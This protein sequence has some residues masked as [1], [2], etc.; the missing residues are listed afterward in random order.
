MAA[1]WRQD[2]CQ[3]AVRVKCKCSY[4]CPHTAHQEI[5]L[6][7]ALQP[8]PQIV[9]VPNK[10]SPAASTWWY[11]GGQG[12]SYPLCLL[13]AWS[14]DREGPAYRASQGPHDKIDPKHTLAF[15]L[16]IS[17]LAELNGHHLLT[18][19]PFPS[20]LPSIHPFPKLCVLVLLKAGPVALERC[21]R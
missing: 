8:S 16:P 17:N 12:S 21:T 14:S 13:R 3:G 9:Q 19:N 18:R 4:Q 11:I 7:F 1:E 2:T 10:V 6:P 15:Q 5:V 20:G